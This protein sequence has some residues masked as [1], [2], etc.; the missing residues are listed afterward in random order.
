MYALQQ[1]PI[2]CRMFT[3]EGYST[4]NTKIV[5]KVTFKIGFSPVLVVQDSDITI[6]ENEFWGSEGL[7]ELLTRKNV[8]KEHV[9]S[10]DVRK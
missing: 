10:D 8:K 1:A 2:S 7:W 9:N 3:S 4:H 6:K 5:R